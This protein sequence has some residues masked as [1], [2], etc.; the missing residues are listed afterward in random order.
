MMKQ[1]KKTAVN[2]CIRRRKEQKTNSSFWTIAN[3]RPGFCGGP[4][5]G[6]TKGVHLG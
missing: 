1:D 2:I 4:S 3:L 6:D 5:S